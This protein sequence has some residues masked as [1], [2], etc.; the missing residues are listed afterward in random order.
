MLLDV[1]YAALI[2]DLCPSLC[3]MFGMATTPEL[4][5]YEPACERYPLWVGEEMHGRHERANLGLLYVL[6]C[7]M[8]L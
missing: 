7:S 8:L 4:G 1:L 2:L 3:L 6:L 5:R